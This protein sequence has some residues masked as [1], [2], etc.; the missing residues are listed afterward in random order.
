[1]RTTSNVARLPR[2]LRFVGIVSALV[3]LIAGFAQAQEPPP[4]PM[5]TPDVQINFSGGGGMVTGAPPDL[6]TLVQQLTDTNLYDGMFIIRNFD[7][8]GFTGTVSFDGMTSDPGVEFFLHSNRLERIEAVTLRNSNA[9]RTNEFGTAAN[10]K[11]LLPRTAAFTDSLGTGFFGTGSVTFENGVLTGLTYSIGAEALT[12]FDFLFVDAG[13]DGSLEQI[14]IDSG[15]VMQFSR[16]IAGGADANAPSAYGLNSNGY[17]QGSTDNTTTRF[18]AS[19]PTLCTARYDDAGMCGGMLDPLNAGIGLNPFTPPVMG[20]E[21]EEVK[22]DLI[23]Y[24][25]HG[26]SSSVTVGPSTPA[27]Q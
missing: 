18:E 10:S 16:T 15:P 20:A 21:G 11:V 7:P 2:A 12:T 14:T 22:A 9:N 19:D 13:I 8:T 5:I 1:M 3:L 25:L 23:V 24:E 27:P 17:I 4:P 6:V 26:L